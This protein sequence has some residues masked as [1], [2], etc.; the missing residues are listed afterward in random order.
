MARTAVSY[1]GADVVTQESVGSLFPVDLMQDVHKHLR[2]AWNWQRG[3]QRAQY[4]QKWGMLEASY[5]DGVE[6]GL[7]TT[8]LTR[9]LRKRVL[10]IVIAGVGPSPPGLERSNLDLI[11]I[12][13]IHARE[14]TTSEV[15]VW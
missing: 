8:S 4:L 6:K 12:D 5:S 7:R 15:C 10:H 1:V 3:V 14:D 11:T 2:C 9:R 13:F